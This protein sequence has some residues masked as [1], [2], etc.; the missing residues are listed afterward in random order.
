LWLDLPNGNLERLG[1]ETFVAGV[2][3][4]RRGPTLPTMPTG[5][6][7]SYA[8][9]T[10]HKNFD[11]TEGKQCGVAAWGGGVM[12]CGKIARW[13][14]RSRVVGLDKWQSRAPGWQLARPLLA[15]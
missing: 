8:C 2:M 9:I 11:F 10:I 12:L 5:L 1:A 13:G 3:A 14:L 15:G 6:V 4:A 7:A